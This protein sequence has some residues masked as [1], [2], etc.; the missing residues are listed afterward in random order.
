MFFQKHQ[1]SPS[2][3]LI[4]R[5]TSHRRGDETAWWKTAGINTSETAR[6]LWLETHPL[7]AMAAEARN[8]APFT[9]VGKDEKPANKIRSLKT[10]GRN[11]KT[12]PITA[13]SPQ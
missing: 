2:R 10:M 1:K 7:P 13:A 5:D 12:K 8:V 3:D 6:A 11:Y 9:A 4:T